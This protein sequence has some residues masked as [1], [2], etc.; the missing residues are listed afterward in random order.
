M[1]FKQNAM[2]YKEYIILQKYEGKTVKQIR[3]DLRKL[4]LLRIRTSNMLKFLFTLACFT[5]PSI[6]FMYIYDAYKLFS[7]VFGFM[8]LMHFILIEVI[9]KPSSGFDLNRK[10]WL[11]IKKVRNELKFA[12][13]NKKFSIDK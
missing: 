13:R 1:Y 7:W 10:K 11:E 6:Y 12:L 9:V 2:D 4:T 8:L 3:R 5:L